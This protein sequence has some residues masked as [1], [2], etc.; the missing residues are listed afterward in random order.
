LGSADEP[1]HLSISQSGRQAELILHTR[2]AVRISA[3]VRGDT[4]VGT[5]VRHGAP[6]C[7]PGVV[8]IQAELGRSEGAEVL[9]GILAIDDCAQCPST[10]FVAHRGPEEES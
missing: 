6:D 4:L 1:G 10:P 7:P 2:P 5:A 3:E 9:N 8:R